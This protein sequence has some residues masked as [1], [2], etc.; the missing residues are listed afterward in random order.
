VNPLFKAAKEIFGFLE[1]Q[2]WPACLIGGLAA[3]CRGRPRATQDVDVSLYTGLGE[4]DRYIDGLL[5][6]FRPR[7]TDA[8]TFALLHRVLLIESTD[9]VG[10]DVA[11]AAFPFEEAMIDRATPFRLGR[12]VVIPTASAED[13]IV[14]KAFA[15]RPIDWMDMKE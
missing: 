4:E 13:V 3:N 15:N 12:G 11:L 6:R 10:I 9:E 7:G 2:A 8:R 1:E 5:K 14:S